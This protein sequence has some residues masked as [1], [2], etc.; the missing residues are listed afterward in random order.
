MDEPTSELDPRARRS[1][2]KLLDKLPQSILVATHDMR[3]VAELF[4]RMIIMDQG[5]IVAEG[6]PR[7]LIN[8]EA[9][10]ED[11]GLERP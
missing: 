6:S 10:L 4:S 7:Q 11:H 2:I 3:M 1:L 5:R 8:D 9:L